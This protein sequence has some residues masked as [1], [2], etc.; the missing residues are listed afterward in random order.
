MATGTT[1]GGQGMPMDMDRAC[2]KAKCFGVWRTR[3]LQTQ[4]PRSTEDQGGGIMKTQLLLGSSP[5]GG[6]DQIKS[7]GGKRWC[8]AVNN[9]TRSAKDLVSSGTLSSP[10]SRTYSSS[11][12]INVLKRTLCAQARNATAS[13]TL[14]T[15]TTQHYTHKPSKFLGWYY[16][17]EADWSNSIK[18]SEYMI[19]TYSDSARRVSRSL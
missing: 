4:L 1:Y 10:A 6:E 19:H 3:T 18:L 11:V 12:V 17:I 2:T 14:I 9:L 15:P 7:Q 16:A 13:K 8:R 5:N